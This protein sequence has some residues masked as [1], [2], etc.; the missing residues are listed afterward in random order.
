MSTHTTS[1]PEAPTETPRSG[2]PGSQLR[3]ARL[4]LKLAPEDVATMLHLSSR[5]IVALENDDYANLP[6][7]TYVRGYLRGYAQLLGVSS[8]PLVESYNRSIAA[9]KPVDLG[10]LGPK[11]EIRSDHRLIKFATLGVV[12]IVIGLSAVWWQEKPEPAAPPPAPVVAGEE[13]GP[14]V[15]PPSDSAGE[16]TPAPPATDTQTTSAPKPAPAPAPVPAPSAPAVES[17]P[18]VAVPAPAPARPAITGP[19]GRLVLQTT[20]DCWADVRD[21]NGERLLY[22]TIPA[23]RTVSVDGV[24][25]LAVF[26]GNAEGVRV[27]FNGQPYDVNRHRRGEIAR[28][29]LTE[30]ASAQ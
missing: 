19:R 15:M 3:Q 27:E 22:E 4:D 29:T 17:A 2:G 7:P 11:P 14:I 26:L 24:L 1:A 21:A 8:E 18:I 28:F 5:Q 6:G 30:S 20:L 25:P 9:R 13:S 23:G 16:E 12:A 10:K